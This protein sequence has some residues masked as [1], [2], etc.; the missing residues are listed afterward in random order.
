MSYCQQFGFDENRRREFVRLAGLEGRADSLAAALQITI[1]PHLEAIVGHFMFHLHGLPE[2]KRLV[3][4]S[5]ADLGGLR[6]AYLRRWLRRDPAALYAR[7]PLLVR[8]GFSLVLHD[9]PGDAARA[10]RA[11]LG[12]R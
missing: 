3:T 5:R 7:W 2:F 11:A 6:R 12:R 10:I 1:G 8:A 9:R 4:Q